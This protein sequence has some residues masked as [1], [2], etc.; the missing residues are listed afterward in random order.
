MK[1]VLILML[2][3]SVSLKTTRVECAAGHEDAA[4]DKKAVLPPC[5]ACSLV[6]QMVSLQHKQDGDR[7]DLDKPVCKSG[8]MG[9]LQ[10]AENV[11]NWKAHLQE[12]ING[13]QDMEGDLRQWLCVNKLEVC[14]PEDRFGKDCEECSIKD[15]AGKICSGNGKCKGAGTRKGNGRCQC[16]EGYRGELCDACDVGYYESYKDKEKLL[17]SQC[18]PSCQLACAGSGARGCVACKSGYAMD[19]EHGCVDLDECLVSRPCA[20]NKF[21]VNT[22]GNYRCLNCDK[23]CNGCDGDGPDSCIKCADGYTQSKDSNVCISEQMASKVFTISNT[24]FFTYIGLCVAAAIIFQRSVAVAGVLG[25]VIAAYISFSEYY[26]MSSSG[27]MKP[28]IG[29]E[30]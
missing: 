30:L 18:H 17:C 4:A 26:L 10:C 1:F 23:A 14:C 13:G 15:K 12:W 22:E 24:R 6:A 3:L 20:G 27:E 19:S 21:C 28:I 9:Q 5:A 7:I 16:N 2:L 8:K 29:G 25:L 11:K